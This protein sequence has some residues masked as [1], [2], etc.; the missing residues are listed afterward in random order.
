MTG[1]AWYQF[2]RL[3]SANI[4]LRG[5]M[6]HSKKTKYSVT[7]Q[8]KEP[9]FSRL[10]GAIAAALELENLARNKFINVI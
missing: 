5:V 6:K 2:L 10:Y 8:H 7:W 4:S 9:Q 3:G 1:Q